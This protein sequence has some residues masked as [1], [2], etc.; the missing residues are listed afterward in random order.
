MTH[1]ALLQIFVD[2]EPNTQFLPEDMLRQL[3][4]LAHHPLHQ[5]TSK[6][7]GRMKGED[8]SNLV[9]IELKKTI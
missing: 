7:I 6:V 3:I 5:E 2:M 9:Q 8:D 1:A 4:I